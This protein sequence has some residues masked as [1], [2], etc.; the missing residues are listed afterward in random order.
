M[1]KKN[2]G[3]DKANIKKKAPSMGGAFVGGVVTGAVTK[4]LSKI[5]PAKYNNDTVNNAVPLVLG[6]ILGLQKNEFIS[7]AGLGMIGAASTKFSAQLG[8]GEV[9]LGEVPDYI[10]VEGLEN[11]GMSPMLGNPG[12]E[13]PY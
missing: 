5:I 12:E 1:S 10:V 6:A 13:S 9:M 3:F 8:L 7:G 11:G 2:L 4:G